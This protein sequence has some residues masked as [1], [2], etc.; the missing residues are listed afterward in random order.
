MATARRCLEGME[1][2]SEFWAQGA[3][4]PRGHH[5]HA[6]SKCVFSDRHRGQRS[7]LCRT[8]RVVSPSQL[9][10]EVWTAPGT[11][12]GCP[13]SH[14]LG[15]LRQRTWREVAGMRRDRNALRS[16]SKST[17]NPEHPRNSQSL[18]N[19]PSLSPCAAPRV[20]PA[21]WLAEPGGQVHTPRATST[22]SRKGLGQLSPHLPRL[23]ERSWQKSLCYP[24]GQGVGRPSSAPS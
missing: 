16:E 7:G 10:W 11:I 18:G 3:L 24:Q 13:H 6:S 2:P 12:P 4:P 14:P 1:E 5:H 9:T 20:G 21:G 19:V 22:I 15:R 23:V 17:L 8:L